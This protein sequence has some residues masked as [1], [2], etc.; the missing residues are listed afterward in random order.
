VQSVNGGG[1]AKVAAG[2]FLEAQIVERGEISV[3]VKPDAPVGD[4]H[5]RLVVSAAGIKSPVI[6]PVVAKIR[7]GIWAEPSAISFG[8]I[9]KGSTAHREVRLYG[10]TADAKIEGTSKALTINAKRVQ[11]VAVIELSINSA[12]IAKEEF[13]EQIKV[14]SLTGEETF[15]PVLA[16]VAQER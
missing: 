1:A 12:L 10:N 11:G 13:Q 3:I 14:T 16:V 7:G 4:L 6:I 9:K 2:K 8:V 15:I 5:D